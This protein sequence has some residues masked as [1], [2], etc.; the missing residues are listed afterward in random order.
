MTALEYYV[1]QTSQTVS[2]DKK[3]IGISG[4]L[5]SDNLELNKK[6]RHANLPKKSL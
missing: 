2:F 3:Q 4:V 1:A 5:L 6:A